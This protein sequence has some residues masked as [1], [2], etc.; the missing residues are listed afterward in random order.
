MKNVTMR[1]C[2]M[3]LIVAGMA[4]VCWANS[5]PTVT[6]VSASQRTD[7]SG[8]V[9]ISYTLS[10]ADGDQ[11]EIQVLVSSD[12]GSTW[13]LEPSSGALSGDVG[14]SI[15]PGSRHITWAS[16]TDLPGVY[17]TQFRVRVTAN[18]GQAAPP[19]AG[20][21]FVP[22]TDPGLPGHGP[23]AL[24]MSKYETTHAQYCQYLNEA[25]ADG[26]IIIRSNY[27][28]YAASDTSYSTPYYYTH[29]TSSD[30]QISYA[31]GLFTVRSRDGHDMSNHPVARVTGHGASAF[32]AYYGWR[33]PTK[34]EWQAVADYDGSYVYGCGTTIDASKLNYD[35]NNP[36]GLTS[37]P[38]TTP[39]GHY[40]EYG[41]GLCDMAGNVWEWTSTD[42]GPHRA[43]C[44]GSWW[45]NA[46]YCQI[47]NFG[48]DPPNGT[49]DNIGFRV[50]R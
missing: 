29:E 21:V 35:M 18:D 28:V 36:L 26:S 20:F 12:G 17:G 37:Q 22:I 11:C 40:P 50:C 15:S 45:Y 24:E 34:A 19:Q 39:V 1:R 25:L 48:L 38:Y 10:D 16:K 32:A 31:N 2:L 30:S 9:D 41:Y 7:G 5:A 3:G 23:V 43:F 4:S 42:E 46:N 47:S 6:G 8:I 27:V 33:L 14:P 13:T 44:G 49:R